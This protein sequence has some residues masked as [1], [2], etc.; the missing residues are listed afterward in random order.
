Q[1]SRSNSLICMSY[2]RRTALPP[3]SESDYET[4]ETAVMESALGQWFLSEHARRNRRAQTDRLLAAIA[5]L[6]QAVGNR[7]DE[8]AATCKQNADRSASHQVKDSDVMG[9]A[10][11][12][13][14]ASNALAAGLDAGSAGA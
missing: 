13:E 5:R 2:R 10:L 1:S 12:G 3:L 6:E 7:I 11:I 14:P 9:H 4:I 8:L